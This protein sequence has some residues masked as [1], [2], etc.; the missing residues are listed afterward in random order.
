MVKE[1]A[2]FV[3]IPDGV[4]VQ[5]EGTILKVSGPKGKLERDFWYPNIKVEKVDSSIKVDT[6]IQRKRQKAILGTFTSHIKNM[7]NGVTEGF[8]YR[9]K[10]VYSHFPIQVKTA[11]SYVLIANFLGERKDRKAKIVGESKVK[12]EGDEVVVTGI[13][14]E[15]VGQT[16]AN[17]E[18]TTKI[19]RFDPRVF[20]DGIYIIVKGGKHVA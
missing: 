17:I 18:Q 8:E 9:L 16:A 12:I 19:S 3:D 13:N 7:I 15:E 10:I 1:T 2:R 11:E 4:D 20:Q 5:I 14:K 6:T